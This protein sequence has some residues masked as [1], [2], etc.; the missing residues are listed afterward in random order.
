MLRRKTYLRIGI[1]VILICILGAVLIRWYVFRHKM[2]TS[3]S[4]RRGVPRVQ[5]VCVPKLKQPGR[6]GQSKEFREIKLF[7][8]IK[9]MSKFVSADGEKSFF[10]HRYGFS[11]EM[12][13]VTLKSTIGFIL[14]RCEDDP[15]IPGNLSMDWQVLYNGDS[16][17]VKGLSWNQKDNLAIWRGADYSVILT[18]EEQIEK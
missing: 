2:H 17:Q 12:S 15:D 3:F 7:D 10:T 11:A 6:G 9:P 5:M 13:E 16:V 4:V 1:A 18:T 14:L 8:S